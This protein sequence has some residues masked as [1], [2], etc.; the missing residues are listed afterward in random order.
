M[1]SKTTLTVAAVILSWALGVALLALYSF[2]FSYWNPNN[3]VSIL[4]SARNGT[5]YLT[6]EVL[7]L[8]G[9]L[10]PLS[11]KDSWGRAILALFL[12][13]L[14]LCLLGMGVMHAPGW[15]IA[16]LIWVV[17][18]C[19]GLAVLATWSGAMVIKKKRVGS[20]GGA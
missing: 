6:G 12:S 8:V 14:W 3:E 10:R 15:Y 16:N 11:Y 5:G 7:A 19:V 17:G 4:E 20:A 13:G 9:L 1:T 18:A 2:E